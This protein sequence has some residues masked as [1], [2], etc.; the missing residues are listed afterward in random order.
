MYHVQSGKMQQIQQE[1]FYAVQKLFNC[2]RVS[3]IS[4]MNNYIVANFVSQIVQITVVYVSHNLEN[5]LDLY[6]TPWNYHHMF[7]FHHSYYRLPM[8]AH[9]LVS[10]HMLIKLCKDLE[11]TKLPDV[12]K[13]SK[14]INDLEKKKDGRE[15]FI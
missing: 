1:S 8:H 15:N 12:V 3:K 10:V 14:W 6:P 5:F 11:S 2:F 4:A 9:I 13:M 7:R